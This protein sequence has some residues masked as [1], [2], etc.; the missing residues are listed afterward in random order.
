MNDPEEKEREAANLRA[1]LT[2]VNKAEFVRQHKVPGGA[3]MVSQNE[4]GHRPISMEG[5]IA[6]AK[7]LKVPL[8]RISKRISE[9]VAEAATLIGEQEKVLRPL[10]PLVPAGYVRL[11]HLSPE[12]SMGP[13]AALSE[14]LQ[15]VR[16]LDVLESWVRQKVGSADYD[17]VKILTGCGQSMYPTIHD[18]DLVFVDINQRTIDVPGIYVVDVYG[19]FLLKRALILSDGTLVLKSDNVEEFPDEERI[20]LLKAQDTVTV[21]GR[22]KAWWTLRKG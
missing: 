20:D 2:G 8:E 11:Q 15:V 14:S 1:L 12:P 10:A 21:A 3:S 22:V 9:Q 13:G 18:Q 4:S 7:G 19:R 5:A 17:R 16:H 6:Y